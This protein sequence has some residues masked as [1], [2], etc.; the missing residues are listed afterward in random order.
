[1]H[2][3]LRCVSLGAAVLLLATVLLV[4]LQP[5][6]M[7][8]TGV[9]AC[10]SSSS[11][12]KVPSVALLLVG[13]YNGPLD[14]LVTAYRAIEMS[15]VAPH[16]ADVYAVT[17]DGKRQQEEAAAA[18]SVFGARLRAFRT[19]PAVGC[20]YGS[21][22]ANSNAT[23]VL[24]LC[25]PLQKYNS[26]YMKPGQFLQWHKLRAA[27]QLMQAFER[28]LSD[29]DEAGD[30]EEGGLRGHYDIVVKLR[31]DAVPIRGGADPQAALPWQIS[32]N[33][34]HAHSK[35]LDS[36]ALHAASDF[37]FWG[38]RDAMQATADVFDSIEAY[39]GEVRPD[40]MLREVAVTPLL[41]SVR[42]APPQSWAR[43]S[44]DFYN[45]LGT[46]PFVELLERGK[47]LPG[48]DRKSLEGPE[49][50]LR[51]EAG[52]T[53]AADA[54]IVIADPEEPR[55]RGRAISVSS[56]EAQPLRCGSHWGS[57]RRRSCWS[58]SHGPIY[59]TYSLQW[60]ISQGYSGNG[61]KQGHVLIKQ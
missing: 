35:A 17:S 49:A 19:V 24:K 28:S 54:R 13:D 7:P 8:W 45:K 61:Y 23:S 31:P 34:C 60:V 46:L 10:S 42:N 29:S 6:L 9:A 37:G 55:D 2:R 4:Q 16:A 43:D 5:G 47:K 20:T 41:Q 40:P 32:N 15:L 26:Q 53:N 21:G 57:D 50:C 52:L 14:D 22:V 38:G 11:S 1:M 36:V 18:L 58:L 27:W 48:P 25:A 30:Q 33:D 39:F 59:S 51:M 12:R 56:S 3:R 44:W